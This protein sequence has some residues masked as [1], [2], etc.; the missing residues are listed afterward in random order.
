MVGMCN[1]HTWNYTKPID[2][3]GRNLRRTFPLIGALMPYFIVYV[4]SAPELLTDRE[5]SDILTVSRRNNT[6]TGVSGALLYQD[7]NFI[8]V[9]EGEETTVRSLYRRIETDPRH[10]GVTELVDGDIAEPDFAEWSMAFGDLSRDSTPLGHHVRDLLNDPSDE[11]SRHLA[12]V[13]LRSFRETMNL[14]TGGY[15]S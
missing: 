7:G 13:L 14:K 15:A 2:M 8:Q 10:H 4:S 9:L 11:P 12:R 1:R 6:R 5:L 3:S